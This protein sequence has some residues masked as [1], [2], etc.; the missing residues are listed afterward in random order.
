MYL[1]VAV[2]ALAP[3]ISLVRVLDQAR[4]EAFWMLSLLKDLAAS[5][6]AVPMHINPYMRLTWQVL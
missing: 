4:E 1:K 5:M 3:L 6:M 2:E